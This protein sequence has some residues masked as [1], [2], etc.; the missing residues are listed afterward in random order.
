MSMAVALS[1][2]EPN[3]DAVASWGRLTHD[4]HVVQPL[5]DRQHLDLGASGDGPALPYGNGRSYGDVCLN[6]GGRLWLTRTLDRFIAFDEAS[7]VIECEAGVLLDEIIAVALPRGWFLPVTPGTRFASLGGAIANDVHGK[8]HHRA[9]TLGE[10]IDSLVLARSD[11]SRRECSREQ[12]AEWLQATIGGLGLTGVIVSAR[13]RLKRAPGAWMLT[14]SLPFETLAGFFDLS[15]ESEPD[16]EYTV[17]WIDCVHGRGPDTRGIFFRAN[18]AAHDA[19]V[20]ANG[21]RTFPFTPPFSLINRAT[22]NA[23]NQGY[24]LSNRLRRGTRLQ[25]LLQFFYPLDGMLEWNRMYGP[26]G[27]FQYQC[28]VPRTCEREATAELLNAIRASGKGSF[29]AVLKTFAAR[30]P[31]GLL[32]FPMAGTTLALDFP[33]EGE[34]TERL[35]MQLDAIVGAAGGRLYPGK[36]ARMPRGLFHQGYPR[37]PE[38]TR[39]RDPGISSAFSR[40]LFDA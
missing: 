4:L 31:A 22:L 28:V 1:R 7:G 11:G 37:L 3:V 15:R 38:F 32:S 5:R 6:P 25:A 24:F 39:F 2:T 30:A 13:L 34:R 26:R 10:H 40:R 27:F 20:P 17:S 35:F 33:N 14:E 19:A 18:H 36:D 16:W 21:T 9:G 12:D 29:L 23:F 8:N